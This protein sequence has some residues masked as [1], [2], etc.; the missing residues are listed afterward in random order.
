MNNESKKNVL[1]T[2]AAGGIGCVAALAF[3]KKG[4]NVVINYKTS[5][6]KAEAL[7]DEI[8]AMGVKALCIRADVSNRSEVN[9]MFD[10]IDKELG[11]IDILIN[12]AG[13]AQQKMFCDITEDDFDSMFNIT[14]K[15]AFNCT[16]AALS[17][18]I[19]KKRG[20]IINISSMWGVCGASCEVHY[21]AAKAALIG[22]TKAL[23]RELA[24]SNI[25]VNCI[26]PGVIDTPMNVSLGE[27]TLNLLRQESPMGR[28]GTPEEVAAL[29][30]FLACG[31]SDFIT[32]Q[33][34]GIDGSFI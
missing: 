13:I 6:E 26:A 1:I 34:I 21:S 16:Q 27:D 14:V 23:A 12:N 31:E 9:S 30:T 5:K 3:A 32:G 17:G 19:H 10:R 28:F 33:I 22:M 24:P 25:Q 18:M 11:S 4:C 29:M 8:N 20:K 7:A 2:G 15:G